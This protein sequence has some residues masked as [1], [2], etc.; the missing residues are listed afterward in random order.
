MNIQQKVYRVLTNFLVISRNFTSLSHEVPYIFRS[1]PRFIGIF[2]L[3]VNT[4][5]QKKF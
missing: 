2:A 3:K 4:N 5:V 1:F